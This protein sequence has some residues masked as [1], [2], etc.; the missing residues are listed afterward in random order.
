MNIQKTID[1]YNIINQNF[2]GKLD[3]TSR[4]MVVYA[5]F[6]FKLPIL[7]HNETNMHKKL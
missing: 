3:A 4:L 1:E 7:R 6:N 5:T 2:E